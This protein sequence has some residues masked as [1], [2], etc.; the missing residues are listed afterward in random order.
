MAQ[1]NINSKSSTRVFLDWIHKTNKTYGQTK[2]S[3]K[4]FYMCL[5]RLDTQDKRINRKK[6]INKSYGQTK[7]SFTD[8]YM[9]LFRLDTQDKLTNKTYDQT[10]FEITYSLKAFYTCLFR[11]DTQD[12]PSNN[13]FIQTILPMS[14][15]NGHTG[16]TE[17]HHI[18]SRH[19]TQ[20]VLEWT[21]RTN[22]IFIQSI[23][24]MYFYNGHT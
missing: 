3:S 4:E 5:F 9:C 8:Y 22:G 24:P 17:Q 19:F 7:Y 12:K 20:V 15:F 21:H 11:M 18:Y 2:F 10:K 6:Q 13:T 14:F 1:Q 23:L 16:Q